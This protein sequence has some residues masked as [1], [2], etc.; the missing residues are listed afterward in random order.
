METLDQFRKI[1]QNRHQYARDWKARTGKQVFGYL[2]TYVPEEVIYAAGILPVRVLG[3]HEPQ[4][5]TEPHIYTMFC[6]FSRDILAQGL[7]GRYNYCDGIVYAHSCLHMRQTFASWTKHVPMKYQRYIFVPAK[8]QSPRAE[9]L[10]TKEVADFRK[11]LEEFT[12]K[13]ITD[14]DLDNAIDVYNTN[15]RL[16]RQVYE[17]RRGEQPLI[18]G[19]EATHMVLS[20]MVSDKAEHNKLLEKALKELPTRK[21]LPKPG[22]RLMVISSI[23]DSV[24]FLEL[25]EG[26]DAIIVIDDVCDGTRYFWNEVQPMEDRNNAI[27]LRYINRPAC[28]AKDWEKRNRFPF[29]LNLAKE[30]NVQG[31]IVVQQKFCDPHEFD[32]PPIM[33]MLKDN[34][35]PSIFLEFDITVPVGQFRTR[36]EAFL[37]MLQLELV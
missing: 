25:C 31:A 11:S 18:S 26:L 34:G 9:P 12:G 27:A 37:E 20:S 6:P 3:S 22:T 5:V 29:I 30:Y 33:N 15:R 23:L 21:D 19:T 8:V 28:P 13:P 24:E 35:I 7:Q 32:I 16:M 14:K 10:L 2:C 36:V 1:F 17:T 4:D